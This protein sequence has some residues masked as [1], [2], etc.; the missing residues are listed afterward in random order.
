MLSVKRLFES[1]RRG[2][3]ADASFESYYGTLVRNQQVG[4][5]TASEARRDF[6]AIRTHVDRSMI[7]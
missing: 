2:I 3:P 7:Y 5:P 6:E 1:L 4:N